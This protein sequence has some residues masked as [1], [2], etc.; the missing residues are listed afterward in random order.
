[1]DFISFLATKIA[2]EGTEKAHEYMVRFQKIQDAFAKDDSNADDLLSKFFADLD[3]ELAVVNKG[4]LKGIWNQYNSKKT[5]PTG[6]N[7]AEAIKDFLDSRRG[8]GRDFNTSSG[9]SSAEKFNVNK[10]RYMGSLRRFLEKELGNGWNTPRSKILIPSLAAAIIGGA[11]SEEDHEV[12]GMALAGAGVGAAGGEVFGGGNQVGTRIIMANDL[13]IHENE[14]IRK[15]GGFARRGDAKGG[16]AY[17]DDRV[18]D[19]KAR[20]KFWDGRLEKFRGRKYQNKAALIGG[21][22]GALGL[23]GF[24]YLKNRASS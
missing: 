5:K 1:M 17:M 9:A 8:E 10:R 23:G 2:A 4:A 11:I 16:A 15:A 3:K 12:S 6:G 24:T 19:I 18:K 21:G 7:Y 13:K 14:T 22:L 20:I